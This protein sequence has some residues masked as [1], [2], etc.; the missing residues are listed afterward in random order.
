MVYRSLHP[1]RLE[2]ALLLMMLPALML[3]LQVLVLLLWES[4]LIQDL[5]TS[6]RIAN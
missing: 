5:Q 1:P 6:G 3:L 4:I 2:V